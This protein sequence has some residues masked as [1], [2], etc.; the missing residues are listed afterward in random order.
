MATRVKA[1]PSASAP[2]KVALSSAT[3]C[4]ETVVI[5]DPPNSQDSAKAPASSSTNIEEIFD[6]AANKKGLGNIDD[7]CPEI[8]N[9]ENIEKQ[10][11]Q[12]EKTLNTKCKGIHEEGRPADAGDEQRQPKPGSEQFV[13]ALTSAIQEGDVNLRTSIGQQFKSWL[14]QNEETNR[15]YNALKAHRGRVHTLKR[16]FR[17]AWATDMQIDHTEVIKEKKNGNTSTQNLAPTSLSRG[18]ASWKV[19][20]T[21]LQLS[22]QLAATSPKRWLLEATGSSS[23]T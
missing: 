14:E 4:T 23:M 5:E 22:Q 19:A 12:L 17:L 15:E 21:R 10:I 11:E 18:S 20:K 3:A 8:L 9:S 16:E 13:N 1:Q 2:I 7:I 6:Q